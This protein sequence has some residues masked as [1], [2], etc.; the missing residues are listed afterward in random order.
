MARTKASEIVQQTKKSRGGPAVDL[1]KVKSASKPVINRKQISQTKKVEIAEKKRVF[2]WHPGTQ[3]KRRVIKQQKVVDKS[4]IQYA[5]GVSAIK[6][7]IARIQETPI[8]SARIA[9][10]DNEKGVPD[11]INHPFR[12]GG[13]YTTA[14]FKAGCVDLLQHTMV[15]LTRAAQQ[16]QRHRRYKESG[17]QSPD[18]AVKLLVADIMAV[19]QNPLQ[20]TY[21]PKIF[22]ASPV[23]SY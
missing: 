16:Y 4:L 12:N 22:Q 8:D 2:R 6:T 3:A 17:L 15:D 18:R 13:Y 19:G 20:T 7:V 9:R 14:A 10:Y 11:Y 21:N 23:E 1:S 5:D